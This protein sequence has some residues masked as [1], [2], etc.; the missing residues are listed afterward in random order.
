MLLLLKSPENT[1]V[2]FFTKA[3]EARF[4]VRIPALEARIYM[5]QIS[6]QTMRSCRTNVNI[7]T[8]PLMLIGDKI[9]NPH[10]ESRYLKFYE[11]TEFKRWQNWTCL[12]HG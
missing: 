9:P 1:S 7:E 10:T 4:S 3:Y 12:N 5:K 6:A 11:R 2:K 8:K